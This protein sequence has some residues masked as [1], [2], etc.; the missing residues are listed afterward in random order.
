MPSAF[1]IYPHS[2]LLSYFLL[3]P[4]LFQN[5]PVRFDIQA[6]RL[7]IKGAVTSKLPFSVLAAGRYTA[8]QVGSFMHEVVLPHDLGGVI[9]QYSLTGRI[10]LL[11]IPVGEEPTEDNIDVISVNLDGRLP[12]LSG[13]PTLFY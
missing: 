4:A 3:H 13:H 5:N 2:P 6:D 1:F 11:I 8:P 7:G 12:D 9:R 10:D